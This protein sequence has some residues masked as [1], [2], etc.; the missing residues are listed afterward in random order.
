LGED[1]V[2]FEVQALDAL[3]SIYESQALIYRLGRDKRAGWLR[4][5][6]EK[7]LREGIEG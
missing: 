1:E 7:G 5:V 2:I 6:Q 3:P 4:N